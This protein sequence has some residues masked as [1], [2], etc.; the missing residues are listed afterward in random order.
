MFE[1]LWSWEGGRFTLKILFFVGK[2]KEDETITRNMKIAGLKKKLLWIEIV[3]LNPPP[4]I[5]IGLIDRS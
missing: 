3:N 4:E 5:W 2:V 1:F